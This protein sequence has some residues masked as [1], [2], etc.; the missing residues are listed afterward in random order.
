M[1]VDVDT[2]RKQI[3]VYW[4]NNIEDVRVLEVCDQYPYYEGDLMLINRHDDRFRFVPR[5]LLR[6]TQKGNRYRP[7]YLE[8]LGFSFLQETFPSMRIDDDGRLSFSHEDL[9]VI[10][11][12]FGGE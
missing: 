12:I 10:K 8:T 11:M 4:I 5:A 1:I 6:L 3:Q 7:D 2:L 9:A